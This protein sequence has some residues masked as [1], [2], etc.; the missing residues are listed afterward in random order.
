MNKKPE[1]K[2]IVF[3]LDGTLMSS[4]STIYKCTLKTLKEFNI[5]GEMPEEEFNL[6]IGHHFQDIFNDFNIVVPDLEGFIDKYKTYYFDFI[7]ESLVYPNVM[8]T[9][10]ALKEKNIPVSLLTT[11]AQDQADKIIDHFGMR[12]YFTIVVGRQNGLPVKPAPDALIKICSL[13]GVPPE[14]TLMVGDS[15]LDIRCGKNAGSYTC[16][17]TFG[18]R[19]REALEKETPDYLISDMK[20]LTGII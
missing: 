3:D 16:G 11:K 2:S 8:E 7:N 18:Y 20:E 12:E 9:L 6:K 14:N 4:N 19:S 13:T 1:I 10:Q 17:V 5:T 15:E